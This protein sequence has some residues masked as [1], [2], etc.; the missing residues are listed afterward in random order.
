MFYQ[1]TFCAAFVVIME[2]DLASIHLVK[3]STA[4]KAYFRLPWAVGSD[5]TMSRPHRDKGQVW[6]INFVSCES[7]P[8]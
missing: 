8:F 1:K 6:A 4:T 2:T 7:T 5:P 3:Y